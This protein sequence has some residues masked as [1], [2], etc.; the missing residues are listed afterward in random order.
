MLALSF[1]A[2]FLSFMVGLRLVPVLLVTAAA[3]FGIAR[4]ENDH[5]LYA[6]A[7]AGAVCLTG[8]IGVSGMRAGL[9]QIG[10]TSAPDPIKLIRA[11]AQGVVLLLAITL[12]LVFLGFLPLMGA[13]MATTP[14]AAT[15]LAPVFGLDREALGPLLAAGRAW[16]MPALLYL[17]AVASGVFAVLAVPAMAMAANVAMHSPNHD[18][19]YGLGR[20]MGALLLLCGLLGVVPGWV[21]RA[22]YALLLEIGLGLLERVGPDGLRSAVIETVAAGRT[23]IG[24]GGP[25]MPLALLYLVWVPCVLWSGAA[26][27]YLR[28][29]T[30]LVDEE[31]AERDDALGPRFEAGDLNALRH[32]RDTSEASVAR[33]GAE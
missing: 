5:V 3:V 19:A 20:Q 32:S 12:L 21:L 26:I 31:T 17:W 11:S 24:A 28:T 1:R 30:D 4:I 25:A 8:L 10:A 13:W 23:A 18:V 29:G 16:G 14:D 33:Y 2:V 22:E 6:A 9:M 27:A 7:L 15:R